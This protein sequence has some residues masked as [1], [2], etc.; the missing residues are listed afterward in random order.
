MK[1]KKEKV[2]VRNVSLSFPPVIRKDK[3]EFRFIP[4]P[5]IFGIL[6]TDGHMKKTRDMRVVGAE[7]LESFLW[8]GFLMNV[9]ISWWAIEFYKANGFETVDSS[10]E[11]LAIEFMSSFSH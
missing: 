8:G 3:P 11:R 10:E 5:S 6:S 2:M 4:L 1:E 9:Q 7:R